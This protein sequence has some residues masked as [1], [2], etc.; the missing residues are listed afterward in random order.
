MAILIANGIF[1][2]GVTVKERAVTVLDQK[3]QEEIKVR[4]IN[5]ADEVASFLNER[6]KDLLIAT[7]IPATES[8][9]KQFVNDNRRSVWVKEG[10]KIKQVMVPL[11]TEMSLIDKN[12]NEVI[13]ITNGEVA[14]KA[15][16]T[17]V[18][19]P[20]NTTYKSE[21]YFSKA[22]G[23]NK[24]EVYVSPVTGWYVSRGEFEKGKRFSGVVRFATPVYGR[25]GFQG[26]VQLALDYRHLAGFTDHVIP[27]S[28]TA[29]FEAD[30]STGNYAYMVDNRGFIISHPNDYHIAGLLPDGTPVPPITAQ[31]QAEL[32]KK[33]QEVLNLT[34][35]GFVDPNMP[36]IASEAMAGKSGIKMYKFANHTKFVAY[37]PIKFYASEF[38]APSGFGW[39]G[40]GVDVEKFN[41]LAT[42][43]TQ[44]IEKEAKA[45][46]TTIILI[47]VISI[48]ILF[49]IAALL[50]RGISRSIAAEVPPG[51]EGEGP[52]Y[53]D[54]DEDK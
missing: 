35:M 16:L 48:V 50:A 32:V 49:A 4:A 25:E 39:I 2:L 18:S 17:N 3:S 8:A 28:S 1:K 29:V 22:K 43:T 51:S 14:P 27:T 12:G 9:Y 10:D 33:G 26:V 5:L 24:G 52:F 20:A 31:N 46:T 45:W 11:Y 37:A 7:I 53:E 47:L 15:R 23:L 42:K 13:K 54:E 6:K 30:A 40:M 36:Q 44:N 41:E 34:M 21:V 19:N 38:P